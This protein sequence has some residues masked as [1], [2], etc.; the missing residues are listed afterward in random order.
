MNLDQIAR[1]LDG[2]LVGDPDL[3][4][5]GLGKIEAAGPGEL[6]FLANPKYTKFLSTTKA[7]AVLVS[8]E[9]EDIS[10]PHIRVADPY[11]GFLLVLEQ[12]NPPKAPGFTGIDPS[13]NIDPDAH[14]AEDVCIGPL[15]YIGKNV[16][17]GRGTVL[18]PGCVILDDVQIGE[19]CK[20]YPNVS[21][22]EECL[23]GNNVIIHDGTVI[24]SDGFG[25]APGASEYRK[26]PQR[27]IVRIEDDVEIG[28][29]CAIDRATIGETLIKKGC[30]LDNLIQIAHNVVIGENTVIAAQTG[31]SGSTKIGR[32]VTVAGQV[33]IVGHITI[34]DK[35]I[36]AAQSGISKDVPAGEIWFG[37]PAQ[38]IMKQKKVEASLRHLPEIA[39][40]VHQLEKLSI[41]LEEKLKKLGE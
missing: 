41:E 36:I 8:K 29:N 27:G 40:K 37:D 34:G 15:V 23:I 12:L 9:F 2:E 39:R 5:K 28:A 25:F 21:I 14:L 26:I 16:T 31:V 6:T 1:L 38:P 30:K 33:G 19:N 32:N 35:S 22:R 17:I 7:S 4:I 3:E 20:F 24:G 18:Y 13:A 10:I 11:L